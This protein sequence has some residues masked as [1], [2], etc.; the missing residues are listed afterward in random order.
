MRIPK[1][2][3]IVALWAAL[4]PVALLGA[5]T[6]ALGADAVG[7]AP[8]K[9]FDQPYALIKNAARSGAAPATRGDSGEDV[10]ANDGKVLIK[11]APLDDPPPEILRVR[12]GWVSHFV[13]AFINDGLVSWQGVDLD[14]AVAISVDRRIRDTRGAPSTTLRHPVFDKNVIGTLQYTGAHLFARK[15]SKSGSE[16]L[17]IVSTMRIQPADL[18]AFVC[19]A[20]A[21]WAAPPVKIEF[22]TDTLASSSEL[23]DEAPSSGTQG[24]I[25]YRKD[26]SGGPVGTVLS[27]I[28]QYMPKPNYR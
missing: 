19:V 7:R 12:R 13:G 6:S 22:M 25:S 18:S 1:C 14:R 21:A 24:Y 27:A 23:L 15:F 26:V 5:A 17:E 9:C 20:N 10:P 16:E 4:T 11:N 3:E 2:L 8:A 28:W